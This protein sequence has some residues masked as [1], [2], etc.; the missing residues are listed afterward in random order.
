MGQLS[1]V[2]AI[3]PCAEGKEIGERTSS[4]QWAMECG[5]GLDTYLLSI[6]VYEFGDCTEVKEDNTPTL[7]KDIVY[8]GK[9]PQHDTPAFNDSEL[10]TQT[11]VLPGWCGRLVLMGPFHTA[12][13]SSRYTCETLAKV[14]VF[15]P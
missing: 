2:P 10:P 14:E 3:G 5:P 4:E 6:Q 11:Q 1:V 9:R 15:S 13:S 12:G 8:H 7:R